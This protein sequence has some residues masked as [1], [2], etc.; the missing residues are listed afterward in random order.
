MKSAVA[1]YFTD[2]LKRIS[3]REKCPNHLLK[4]LNDLIVKFGQL[5]DIAIGKLFKKSFARFRGLG[6]KSRPFLIHQS[7]PINEKS[8]I[9]SL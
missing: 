9:M 1:V 5:T 6:L 3:L 8:C 7:A 4:W 2:H